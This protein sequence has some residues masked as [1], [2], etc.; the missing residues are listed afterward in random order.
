MQMR[1][2]KDRQESGQG[3]S[4][5]N[6]TSLPNIARLEAK[7]APQPLLISTNPDLYIACKVQADWHFVLLR[8]LF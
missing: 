5:V 3:E 2:L 1:M 7:L 8:C 4:V 6:A